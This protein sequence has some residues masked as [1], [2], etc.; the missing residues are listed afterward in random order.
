MTPGSTTDRLHDLGRLASPLGHQPPSTW[1]SHQP[2]RVL[3]RN[4]YRNACEVSRR[5]HRILISFL[6]LFLEVWED[7]SRRAEVESKPIMEEAIAY[8]GEME[9]T[10]NEV[11]AFGSTPPGQRPTG[12]SDLL[13]SNLPHLVQP[14]PMT[15]SVW[16]SLTLR[17]GHESHLTS[18]L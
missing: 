7:N 11:Q 6:S 16:V 13:P 10:E 2:Q 3:V 14:D 12:S 5:K 9:C 15:L 1:E 4:Q 18:V 8:K 17:R